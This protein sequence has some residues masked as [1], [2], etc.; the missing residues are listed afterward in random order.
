V[1]RPTHKELTGKIEAAK[2]ALAE[3]RIDY[4]NR[5]DIASE[6]L[7]LGYLFED[8]F[9]EIFSEL[10]DNTKPEH[11]AGSRPPLRS[12]EKEIKNMELFAFNVRSEILGR[13]IYYKFSIRKN[14]CYVV[15]LHGDR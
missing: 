6:A 14:Y 10:L 9:P 1:K 7:K 2:R 11:Y 4:I 5:K 8:E 13:I 12:Y 3:M 15:S